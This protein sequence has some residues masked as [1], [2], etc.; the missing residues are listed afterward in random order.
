MPS[1]EPFHFEKSFEVLSFQIDPFGKLRLSALGDLLQEVAWKHADSRDFGKALFDRGYMWVLSRIQIKIHKMPSWGDKILVK[2]AGRGIL[3][4]FALRE[5]LVEDGEGNL[6]AESMSAWLLL[7]IHSKR[8]QRP[9]HVLPAELFSENADLELLPGKIE[10]PLD[11]EIRSEINVMP[12]DLDM[13]NHV[14]NVSYIRWVEDFCIN[15]GAAI[16][17]LLINYLSEAKVN[18]CI[19]LAS[20][21]Q[22]NVIVLSGLSDQKPVFLAE[23]K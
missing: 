10:M 12:F 5:F 8:P 17:D 9:S 19:S 18:D 1:K 20:S 3:K 6:I 2:T 13:N 7:D 14:N 16:N 11:P 23:V 21:D 15:K 22:N 4:L